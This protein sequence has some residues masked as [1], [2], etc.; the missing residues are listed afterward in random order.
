MRNK[1]K[2]LLVYLFS[3][4]GILIWM[5]AA[6]LAPYL[7]N[8][9]SGLSSFLYGCF[10]PICHQIPSRSFFVFGHPFAVCARCLG[11]YTG[12]LGGL[13]LYPLRRGFSSTELPNTR[14]FLAVS[15][16]IVMDTAAN[17]LH[18][19]STSNEL[20]FSFGILWGLILPYYFIAGIAELA[21]QYHKN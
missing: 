10:S 7:R 14:L 5:G 6:T 12:F 15:T 2:I 21:M 18:L 17:F 20:R 3:V 1:R 9:A 13:I 4:L 16:P 8:R 11:I 19:W